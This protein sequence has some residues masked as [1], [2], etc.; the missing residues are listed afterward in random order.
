MCRVKMINLRK[1]LPYLVYSC[2]SVS[3][4]ISIN[5]A[6]R[7]PK[8]KFILAYHKLICKACHNYQ[9]QNDII[10]KALSTSYKEIRGLSAEKKDDIIS[11]L[12]N[13]PH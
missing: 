3:A 7:T 9:Y 13:H 6:E 12:K 2:K 11:S 10:E 1:F 4:I 8:E 5:P